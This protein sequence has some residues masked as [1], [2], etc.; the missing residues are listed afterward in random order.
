MGLK[1][2]EYSGA[3]RLDEVGRDFVWEYEIIKSF[4]SIT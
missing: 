2:R 1:I 4:Y 3:G